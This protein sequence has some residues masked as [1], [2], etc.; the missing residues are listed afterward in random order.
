MPPRYGILLQW[1]FLSNKLQRLLPVA[2][3]LLLLLRRL[4]HSTLQ[5]LGSVQVR[6]GT[7]CHA[8]AFAGRNSSIRIFDALFPADVCELHHCLLHDCLLLKLGNLLLHTGLLGRPRKT[9]VTTH[10]VGTPGT[11]DQT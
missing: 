7:V 11:K 10:S 3:L 1:T 2:A 6:F 4:H 9:I 8:L 5:K